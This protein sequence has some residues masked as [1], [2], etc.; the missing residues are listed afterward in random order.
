[1]K[2]RE[3]ERETLAPEFVDL[4]EQTILSHSLTCSKCFNLVDKKNGLVR[5]LVK[6]I[7]IK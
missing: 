7:M 2:K 5:N 6:I 4:S 3:R 1:M